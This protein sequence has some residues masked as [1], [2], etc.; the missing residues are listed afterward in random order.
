MKKA[1]LLAA[2]MP[3]AVCYAESWSLSNKDWKM[4]VAPSGDIVGLTDPAG[5][6][7]VLPDS[8]DNLVRLAVLP[9]ENYTQAK[10]ETWVVC[11]QPSSSEIFKHKAVLVYRFKAPL[12]MQVKVEIGLEPKDGYQAV[13]RDVTITPVDSPIKKNLLLQVGNTIAQPGEKQEVFLPLYSGLGQ[14]I[15]ASQDIQGIWYL[16]GG[17]LRTSDS[18]EQLAIPLLSVGGPDGRQVTHL[19]DPFF[20]V[21][22]QV[23]DP[24]GR[25]GGRL[26]CI[27]Q[28]AAVPI[29]K[30]QTRTFW[31]VLHRGGARAAMD[32][33]YA[34]ALADIPDGPGWLHEIAW[35]HYDYLS[36]GGRGWR[37]D[38]DA[39]AR[40]IPEA[41]RDRI[42]FTLHGWYDVVGRYC[43]DQESGRLD[44]TWTAFPNAQNTQKHFPT[45][46]SVSMTLEE[47]HERIGHAKNK[48][49]RVALYFAD[50]VTAC[51][52]CGYDD[53]HEILS[54]GGWQ[55][56]DTLG[57][58]Y[59]KNP[60]HPRVRARFKGYLRALLDEYGERIDALVWDETFT[61]SADSIGRYPSPDY[62]ARAMMRLARECTLIVSEYNKTHDKKIAFLTSDCQGVTNDGHNYWLNVPA[63]AIMAHGTYQ[64]SHCQPETWPYGIFANYRNTLW[65]CNWM[66]VTHFDYTA[67]G[68]EHYRTPVATS[69]G[70]LD[71]KGIARLNDEQRQAYVRL[72]NRIKDKPQ[73]L[74]WLKEPPKPFEKEDYVI[75]QYVD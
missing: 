46:E 34:Y 61:V 69:N 10:P 60:A 71:D 25:R 47:M 73:Q 30:P 56:P 1:I 33:W 66:P 4:V 35:Q 5:K 9:D 45:T 16:N 3:L 32:A 40:L 59:F 53:P 31:T 50:G 54:E 13:R 67:Y 11:D 43:Y 21:G 52:G 49:F 20:A 70:W 15:D 65:S 26:N 17:V 68:V 24:G 38:I 39:L 27:Y 72:F 12:A 28:A 36:H 29:E 57:K 51:T 64:D 19:A 44:R 62:A 58:S 22:M 23:A 18:Q 37:E 48:G 14:R 55:G 7:Y 2:L 75:D 63:Y 8:G 41:D 74:H 6:E 42:I